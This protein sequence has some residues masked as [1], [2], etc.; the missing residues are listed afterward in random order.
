MSVLLEKG[1]VTLGDRLPTEGPGGNSEEF[2]REGV[3]N[4][5]NTRYTVGIWQ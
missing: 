3:V 1:T 4:Y 5:G 2:L